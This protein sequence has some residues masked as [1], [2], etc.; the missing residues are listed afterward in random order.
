MWGSDNS[1]TR[2][3]ELSNNTNTLAHHS[4]SLHS[5]RSLN[6]SQGRVPPPAR[7]GGG[8]AAAHNTTT[9]SS[10]GGLP[11]AVGG[12]GP[13]ISCSP[14][15][16]SLSTMLPTSA[17]GGA[18]SAAGGTGGSHNGVAA[19]ASLQ[20][21][22]DRCCFAIAAFIDL[23][24]AV[25]LSSCKHCSRKRWRTCSVVRGVVQPASN[26]THRCHG[27]WWGSRLE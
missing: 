17:Y 27:W 19:M 1:I 14:S 24:A 22:G 8:G 18:P 7:I 12:G 4:A 6:N 11:A 15:S 26:G 13:Q 10:S 16:V 20:H 21:S 5:V 25:P 9:S 2:R 23:R 3:S